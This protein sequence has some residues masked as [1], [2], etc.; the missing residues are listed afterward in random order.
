MINLGCPSCQHSWPLV[1][2][3]LYLCPRCRGNLQVEYDLEHIR[4]FWTKDDLCDKPFD[5]WRYLPLYPVKQPISGP[6][7]GG[8]PCFSA[9]KLAQLVGAKEVWIKNEGTNPSASFKCRASA[10]ALQ[11]A[12]EHGYS[13][14]GAAST[15]N[16]G[17][18]AALWAAV[19]GQPAYIFLPQ[20][21]P[22]AKVAQLMAFGARVLM[23]RGTYDQAF[24]LCQ[25]A[26]ETWGWYNRNTGVNPLTREGKKSVSF[27]IAEQF[28][29]NP[30]EVV[31][32]SVGDGNIISG[33]W[34][35][36]D[37]LFRLGWISQR[38]KLLAVQAEGS[39]SVARAWATNSSISPVSATTL[40]D[41]ISVDLP[42]D[43]DFAL[44]AI[45]SSEGWAIQVTDQAIVQAIP[46]LAQKAGVFAEPAASATWA[47]LV[48]AAECGWLAPD[49]RMLL[50][51]TGHGLKDIGAVQKSV[52]FPPLI[53]PSLDALQQF[54][55]Q[56]P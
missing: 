55:E 25:Q 47:G 39:A 37:E 52:G 23:V 40:A 21:A 8:T 56:H 54:L 27:E 42:R 29:W 33:V 7:V 35:G 24:D 36:F 41:S 44:R 28:S 5:L 16:A 22:P 2:P 6:P 53:E 50:L 51:I 13:T 10:M 3:L 20:T 15:G 32:V 38:P 31:V 12:S 48:A 11:W 43:G 30:P 26:C 46:E 19:L 18:A 45:R 1:A 9:P 17:A 49:W 14:I 4:S 34:K